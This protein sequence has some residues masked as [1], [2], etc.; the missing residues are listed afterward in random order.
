MMAP[1]DDHRRQ[2]SRRGRRLAVALLPLAAALNGAYAQSVGAESA[3]AG[4]GLVIVPSYSV[5]ETFTDNRDLGPNRR[6]DAYTDGT[7]GLRMSSTGGRVRGFLD[8]AL[9]GTAYASDGNLSDTRNAL[10]SAVTAELLE[11]KAYVDVR[12]SIS[13][14]VIS[15]FGTLSSS[16]STAR[17]RNTAEVRSLSISPYMMGS[18]LGGYVDYDARL[19][20]QSTS[21]EVGNGASGSDMA[22]LSFSHAGRSR[23]GWVL[24]GSVQRSDYKTGRNVADDRVNA[25]LLLLPMNDLQLGLTGGMESTNLVTLDRENHTTRGFSVRWSPS[26]RTLFDGRVDQRFF[27]Q[28]HQILATHRTAR[29]TW[30]FTDTRDLSTSDPGSLRYTTEY[31]YL[32][33]Q[34]RAANPGI[35]DATLQEFLLKATQGR[36]SPTSPGSFLPFVTTGATLNRRQAAAFSYTFPRTVF[37]L[38]YNRSETQSLGSQQFE[39]NLPGSGS[40]VNLVRQRGVTFGATHKLTP[41][42]SLSSAFTWQRTL[43]DTSALSA[44]LRT[45]TIDWTTSLDPRRQAGLGFRREEYSGVAA[46]YDANSVYASYRQ[47]F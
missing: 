11:K 45:L 42:T 38:S 27:G 2:R 13:R 30:S 20:H 41:I 12:A 1:A 5:R 22:S 3:T 6:A 10:A 35:D 9:T 43:G 17:N 40:F 37:S 25:T 7:L 31:G 8:Y 29:T 36:L 44:T 46:P 19:T 39:V 18:V 24:D 32:I 21:G 16:D 4:R 28:S 34:L 26:P 14:Q 15:P 33:G 47:Q 23:V